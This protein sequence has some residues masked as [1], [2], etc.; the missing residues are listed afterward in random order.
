MSFTKPLAE[1]ERAL[2]EA[3]FRAE[4]ARL[5]RAMRERETRQ[6]RFE[7]L[8]RVLGSRDPSIIDPLLDLG[9]REENVTALTMAP[10]VCVAWAERSIGD[11]ERR[12]LL[13]AESALGIPPTSEAG[14]LL[15]VWLAHRPH[16]RL[17]DA[18]AAY[19]AELGC[20]LSAEDRDRLRRDIVSWSW[21]VARTLEKTMLRGGAPSR[22]ERAVLER[23]EDALHFDGE[24]D[25]PF[26]PGAHPGRADAVIASMT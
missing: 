18:W 8:S 7:A 25:S 21:K 20:V 11:D 13:A 22:A 15:S 16:P 5:L 3:F 9:L 19:V 14:R 23:I 4:S 2:E 24:H 6:A 12:T 17:L 1:R 26:G 10:L